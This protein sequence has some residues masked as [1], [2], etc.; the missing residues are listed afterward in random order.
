MRYKSIYADKN[1]K[2]Y[3]CAVDEGIGGYRT[4]SLDVVY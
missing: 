2:L 3:I 1:V 4:P